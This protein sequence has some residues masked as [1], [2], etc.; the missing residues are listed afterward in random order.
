MANIPPRGGGKL[1]RTAIWLY[2]VI[3]TGVNLLLALATYLSPQNIVSYWWFP[4]V[5]GILSFFAALA[6]FIAYFDDEVPN[7]VAWPSILFNGAITI[8]IFAL[9]HSAYGII[10]TG[11]LAG[12]G[13][14][15][16]DLADTI[17]FSVVTF[18]TLGYGDF[19]PSSGMRGLA[20]A[21]AL[22]GYV[23]LG[24]LVG[25]AVH[26]VSMNRAAASPL[27]SLNPS[28]L[29]ALANNREQEAEERAA[30]KRKDRNRKARE[31]AAKKRAAEKPK[32]KNDDE[33]KTPRSPE[34]GNG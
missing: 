9:V 12:R 8:F 24:F 16:H 11:P 26:W 27:E 18:T 6:S 10:Y 7:P 30:K 14:S 15:R 13:D 22:L 28:E 17:Y 19:Q 31:R 20:A 1:P 5:L 29:R 32:A 2:A 25:A 34:G 23:Y 33:P 4:W 3:P 21:E